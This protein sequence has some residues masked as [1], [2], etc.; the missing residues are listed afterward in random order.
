MRSA[1]PR[2]TRS[3]AIVSSPQN[4][5]TVPGVSKKE[6]ANVCA[7]GGSPS[8]PMTSRP[9]HANPFGVFSSVPKPVPPEISNRN[10]STGSTSLAIAKTTT[11]MMYGA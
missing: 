11:M 1:S 3:A 8:A 9:G 5:T 7:D 6:N 2:L 10:C 4:S